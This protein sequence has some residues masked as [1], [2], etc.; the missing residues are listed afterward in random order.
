MACLRRQTNDRADRAHCRVSSLAFSP[1][2]SCWPR[3]A[4]IEPSVS[5]MSRGQLR[6]TLEGHSEFVR[7]LVFTRDGKTLISSGKDG[8]IRIWNVETAK[9]IKKLEGHQGSGALAGIVAGRQT[10]YI[11]RP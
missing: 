6:A 4:G 8:I 11:R 1:T 7:D 5:G 3:E 10:A 9:L 2:A